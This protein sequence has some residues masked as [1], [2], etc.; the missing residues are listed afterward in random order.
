MAFFEKTKHEPSILNRRKTRIDS[1]FGA[2]L[3][4]MLGSNP[5]S[6]TRSTNGVQLSVGSEA[7]ADTADLAPLV[8]A[9]TNDGSRREV[10]ALAMTKNTIL[11]KVSN[12]V[13]TTK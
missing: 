3:T 13:T 8:P 5:A 12:Q 11:A 7:G 4:S 10:H 2:N 9:G 1:I 6:A